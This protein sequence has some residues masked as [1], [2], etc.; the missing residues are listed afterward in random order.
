MRENLAFPLEVASAPTAE[1]DARVARDGR[2]ARASTALLE[3]KPR[4]LSGG[5][6][7]RVALG[8]ALV[9]RPRLFLFDEPLSNLDAA[10]RAQMRAE[11]KKLHEALAR[12]VRLRHPRSGRGDD[13]L[14]SGGG[15]AR[16]RA[17]QQVGPP[18][19]L[20]DRPA[21]LFVA[22]FFGSPPINL[23]P[24]AVLG[25]AAAPERA[26]AGVRPEHLELGL[27]APAP[28][29]A[30]GSVYLVEPLGAESLVTVA[31]G[32]RRVV[33]RAAPDFEAPVGAPAWV[34]P[35]AGKVLFFA[36]DPSGARIG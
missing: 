33:A 23:V 5:Q 17:V 26:I 19:E 4:E 20:Y 22:E 18:R 31:I 7:Q 11:L 32:E 3:R 10:L 2:A 8:R 21:N 1:R 29:A 34:R 24:P 14:R 9:R 27:G 16:G 12:D 36:D 13:A 35:H 30:A 15:D 28:G 25:I 6:R